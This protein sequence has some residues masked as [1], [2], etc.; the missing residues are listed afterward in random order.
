MLQE[1]ELLKKIFRFLLNVTKLQYHHTRI[2]LFKNVEHFYYD[3]DYVSGIFFKVPYWYF[4]Q[5]K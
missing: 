4:F 2:T 3:R 1:F 5:D